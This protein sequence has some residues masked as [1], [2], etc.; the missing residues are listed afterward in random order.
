MVWV[1]LGRR[2]GP[3]YLSSFRNALERLGDGHPD[4]ALQVDR[5]TAAMVNLVGLGVRLHREP[6]ADWIDNEL[7][8]FRTRVRDLLT[9]VRP[10][11]SGYLARM[12]TSIWEN[13]LDGWYDASIRR[14]AVQVVM[15][16]FADGDD[17]PLIDPHRISE[18]DAEMRD[19]APEIPPLPPEAVPDLPSTHWWWRAPDVG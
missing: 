6:D 18:A 15:D 7:P 8:A 1:D 4:D 17:R 16:E 10:I 11:L 5:L 9:A 13:S 19:A 14:S 12:E 2:S 3:E